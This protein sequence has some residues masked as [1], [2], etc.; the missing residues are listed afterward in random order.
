M[1]RPQYTPEQ[2]K[3]AFWNKVNKDGSI[4]IHCP[5]L[6]KCWEWIA[7]KTGTGYGNI[8]HRGNYTLA[9]KVSW[10]MINGEV[11]KGLEVCHKCDNRACVNPEHLFIGTHLE[12]MQD[13]DAKGRHNQKYGVE[14]GVPKLDDDK[15]RYIRQRYEQD[16]INVTQLAREMN[17][18]R[19]T[20]WNI[21]HYRKWKHVH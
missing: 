14:N 6:G 5:E 20:V 1:A 11:P 13:R 19:T 16:K 18:G 10:E 4:P 9:H 17:V 12:N 7:G 8:G 21:V 3:I 15:V 2:F